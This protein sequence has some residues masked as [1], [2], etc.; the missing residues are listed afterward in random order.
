M[1]PA[2]MYGGYGGGGYWPGS[3]GGTPMGMPGMGYASS[4]DIPYL[5]S[6]GEQNKNLRNQLYTHEKSTGD[7]VNGAGIGFG[8]GAGAGALIGGIAAKAAGVTSKFGWPGA[9]IGA[10]LLGGVGVFAGGAIGQDKGTATAYHHDTGDNGI[11]DGS[12]AYSG[13][14]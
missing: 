7:M 5:T 9:V 14:H 6:S 2:M 13:G 10:I 1:N 12:P 4:Q 3:G 11:S 8:V